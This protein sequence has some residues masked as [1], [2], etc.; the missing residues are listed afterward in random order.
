MRLELATFEVRDIVLGTETALADG[1]LTVDEHALR[2]LLLVDDHFADVTI[3][4]VRPGDDVRVVH[5]IDAVEPRLRVDE[6]G[7]DFAGMLGM[8]ARLGEGRT[9]RLA[10]VAVLETSEPIAGEPIYWREAIVDM[11]GPGSA[12]SPFSGLVNLILGFTPRTDLVESSA[13]PS[14]LFE[15]T[16]EALEYNRAMRIAGL[17]ASVF[18]AKATG[19]LE[20]DSVEVLEHTA[21]DGTEHPGVVYVY[22]LAI[23]YL[24]GEIAPGA[25]V[26]GGPAH[27]PTIIHPNEILDGALVCG[28]NAIACVRELTYLL[29][30]HATVLDLY[31]R[32]GVDLDFRG[33]VLITNGDTTEAKERLANHGAN[34]VQALGGDAAIIAYAGGGHPCV[35]AMMVCQKLEQRGVSTTMLMME[36]APNPED[37]GFVHYVPEANAIVSTGNFEEKIDLGAVSRVIGGDRILVSGEEASGALTLPLSRLL[38]STNQFGDTTLRGAEV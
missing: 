21:H 20:P 34:L 32:H 31:R 26:I 23:P 29:Q 30:N 25:G 17:K 3:D 6:P 11:A 33:V 8:P 1:V 16:P 18:L 37:S 35:D 15:G 24:Y 38:G 12:H 2:E 4:V 22:Q 36:M 5:I 28:W 10:G 14:N 27:L 13:T 9:N 19:G 7:T